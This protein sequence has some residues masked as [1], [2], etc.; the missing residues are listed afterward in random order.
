MSKDE[1]MTNDENIPKNTRIIL[2]R[3]IHNDIPPTIR[4]C[5]F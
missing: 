1:G 5:A 2:S 4:V 3:E